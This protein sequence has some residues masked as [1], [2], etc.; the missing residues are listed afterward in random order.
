MVSPE[1]MKKKVDK[2]GKKAKK[3]GRE[4]RD[5]DEKEEGEEEVSTADGGSDG[6]GAMGEELNNQE[7]GNTVMED[8]MARYSRALGMMGKHYSGP[9]A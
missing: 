8:Q 1:E 6:G 7:T 4:L 2:A 9:T 3:T 5:E